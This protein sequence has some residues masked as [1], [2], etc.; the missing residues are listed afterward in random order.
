MRR[1]PRF[2]CLAILQNRYIPEADLAP[3]TLQLIH[4]FS[5]LRFH[6]TRTC[7]LQDALV[8]RGGRNMRNAL[9]IFA[10]AAL[11]VTYL[12]AMPQ[13]DASNMSMMQSCPMKVAGAEA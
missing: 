3:L 12:N 8:R 13:H 7:G 11:S 2:L 1:L 6:L 5:Y 9:M 4:I 10:L